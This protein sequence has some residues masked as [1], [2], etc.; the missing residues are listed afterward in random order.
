MKKLFSLVAMQLAD[1][2]DFSFTKK[3]R[4]ALFTIILTLVKFVVVTVAFYLLFMVCSILGVF[5]LGKEMPDTVIAVIFTIIQLLS[6]IT[7]TVGLTGSLYK[8]QDN[9]VLLTL[10]VEHNQVF[11]S[12]LIMYFVYEIRKN[13]FF[14]LPLFIAYGINNSAIFYYYL[15]LI[16][17]F[18]LVSL[19]P[20]AV[21][22]V[23]S[24]PWLYISQ[25]IDK[26]KVLQGVLIITIVLI[27]AEVLFKL[28]SII[29]ENINIV[30][31]WNNISEYVIKPFLTKFTEI[32]SPFYYVTLMIVGGTLAIS[33]N[34]FS[35][36]ALLYF[37]VL[38]A[39]LAVCITIAYLL[40]KPLFFKMASKQ[41]E[42][43]KK[44]TPPK[45]NKVHNRYLSPLFQD[46]I[47]NF[48]S[49]KYIVNVM[50]QLLLPSILIFLLNKLYSAM[51]TSFNGQF[52]T[53]AF[54][55]LVLYLTV[56]S[57]NNEYACV[58][59]KDG[60]ARF[61]EKTRPISPWVLTFSRLVPR[62]I[63]STISVVCATTFYV[64]TSG[65]STFEFVCVA[66][67]G[68]ALSVA[69]LLWS[70]EMDIMN[71]QSDQYAT[72]GLEF[73]NPNVKKAT[74]FALLISA[75]FA[76]L[77]YFLAPSGLNSAF[78]KLAIISLLFMSSRVYLYFIRVKLYYK[79]R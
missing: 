11:F 65:A 18:V 75:I 5:G 55:M 52:M 40:A 45:K 8:S 54:N 17:G 27:I 73:D 4:S 47:G 39:F 30:A 63:I 34:I 14:T 31:Q 60:N 76:F 70:A 21:G 51:Q 78:I 3:F 16:V 53:K 26:H 64:Y 71:P 69:H 42:Y 79:E 29:P 44:V 1:K 15:W 23:L 66:I 61:I 58:Y 59:S 6:I 12:K 46:L 28:V 43:E 50:L 20:V 24:I 74:L 37:L 32:F 33:K 9:R 57:F 48:R 2:L 62:I 22:A 19:L 36:Y 13:F 10:P 49:S 56:L 38:I 67:T 77:V 35:G 72:L 41:F 7:C 25:F 68:S